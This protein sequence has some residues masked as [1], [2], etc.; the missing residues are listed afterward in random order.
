MLKELGISDDFLKENQSDLCQSAPFKKS[1]PWTQHNKEVRREEV[2][3][4]HFEYGYS[5]RKIADLMKISRNTINSDLRYWY[6]TIATINNIV[7]PEVAVG[8]CIERLEIQYT[9]LREQWDETNS[10]QER[11]TLERH[12]LDVSSKIAYIYQRRAESHTRMIDLITQSINN[13]MKDNGKDARYVSMQDRQ[14]VSSSA[15]KKIQHIIKE[16]Q[17]LGDPD[18]R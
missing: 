12:M 2:N 4:L 16:D 6:S 15:Y 14:R 3:R 18:L 9:R 8:V 1:G 11:N 17:K 13:W 7:D 10:Q 5:A